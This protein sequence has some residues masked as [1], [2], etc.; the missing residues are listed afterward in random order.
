LDSGKKKSKRKPKENQLR[1]K[2]WRLRQKEIPNKF[3]FCFPAPPEK[4]TRGFVGFFFGFLFAGTPNLFGGAEFLLVFFWFS[5]GFF[6]ASSP[7]RRGVVQEPPPTSSGRPPR[8]PPDHKATERGRAFGE[9]DP[10]DAANPPGA[11]TVSGYPGEQSRW[12][13]KQKNF[14][15]FLKAFLLPNRCDL[16]VQYR[17][18]DGE[19]IDQGQE[20]RAEYPFIQANR[21]AFLI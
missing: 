19:S 11:H 18:T 4:I 5:F 2:G 15:F 14:D 10:P 8:K 3:V 21:P 7:G 13:P 17:E 20:K 6:F 9:S 16:H 1:Q 12:G